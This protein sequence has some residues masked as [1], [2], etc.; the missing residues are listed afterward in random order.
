MW[1]NYFISKWD[2]YA[3]ANPL[4]FDLLREGIPGEVPKFKSEAIEDYQRFRTIM[5]VLDLLCLDLDTF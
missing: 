1:A 3:N 2:I 4:D 5:Q